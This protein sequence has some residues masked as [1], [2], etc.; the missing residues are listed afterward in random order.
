MKLTGA[1]S[2]GIGYTLLKF[3]LN[4]LKIA[5]VIQKSILIMRRPAEWL[6]TAENVICHPTFE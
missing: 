5:R 4:R 3:Q 1:I 2:T 6:E